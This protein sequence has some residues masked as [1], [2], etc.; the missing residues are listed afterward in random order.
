[1]CD[2]NAPH[3]QKEDKARDYLEAVRWPDGAVCPHCGGCDRVYAIAPDEEKKIRKGLYQCNDCDQQFTVTV[4]TVFERS[5]APLHKWLLATYLMSSSK[6]GISAKQIERHLGVTYKTAWFMCHR[7]REAMKDHK[8]LL[9]GDGKTVEVDETFWGGEARKKLKPK[10]ARGYHHKEKIFALVERNGRARS[11][12]VNSIGGKTIFP[13]MKEH[14]AAD[15]HIN[16]DEG[17]NYVHAAQNKENKSRPLEKIFDK[18]S[19]VKHSTGEYVNGDIYTNTI[20]GFFSIFKRGINGVYQHCSSQHLQRY[21]N[22]FDF[23]YSFREKLGYDDM[24]R[25]D[26][27]LKGIEGKRLMYRDSSPV[28]E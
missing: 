12:H 19:Y 6:K 15:T 21:L 2:L 25:T 14:I 16:T 13:I 7:I 8:G 18:H 5:K 4:G 9:G 10:K 22:E 20:E 17:S 3:F 27:A 28:V 1:M 11:F 26:I 24:A 23:R